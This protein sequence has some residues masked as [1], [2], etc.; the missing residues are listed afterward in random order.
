MLLLEAEWRG[1]VSLNKDQ[2]GRS[3]CGFQIKLKHSG[4]F[5]PAWWVV[6]WPDNGEKGQEERGKRRCNT[7]IYRP[8]EMS[9]RVVL[10][11]TYASHSK[12]ELQTRLDQGMLAMSSTKYVLFS[13][14]SFIT[15]REGA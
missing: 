13:L 7:C 1:F 10:N 6:R 11:I 14:V 5:F 4:F 8:R 3:A 12:C 15:Q 2:V 9:C